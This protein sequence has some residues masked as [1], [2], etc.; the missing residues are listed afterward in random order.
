MDYLD[1]DDI[2]FL[3]VFAHNLIS[4]PF[5]SPV[6]FK[7]PFFPVNLCIGGDQDPK[8]HIYIYIYISLISHP[9]L[10]SQWSFTIF[11]GLVVVPPTPLKNDGVR[12][13]G[14]WHSQ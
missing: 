3:S 4:N 5:L 7:L 6:P 2:L 8:L 9:K 12:Q 13:L 1:F 14:L 10:P 11:I